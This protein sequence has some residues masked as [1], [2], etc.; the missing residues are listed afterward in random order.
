MNEVIKNTSRISLFVYIL[1][2][3]FTYFYPNPNKESIIYIIVFC[4]AT[5]FNCAVFTYF[6]TFYMI[7]QEKQ[8]LR[9]IRNERKD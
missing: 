6:H 2:L 1:C 8:E 3:S 9:R 4:G 7:E 5:V